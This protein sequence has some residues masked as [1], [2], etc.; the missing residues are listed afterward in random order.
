MCLS[1]LFR[2]FTCTTNRGSTV[3]G[4]LWQH[5]ERVLRYANRSHTM[6]ACGI[7]AGLSHLSLA[8]CCSCA[9]RR[10]LLCYHD[11][12]LHFR[13]LESCGLCS[14]LKYS[15]PMSSVPVSSTVFNEIA[16]IHSPTLSN[17]PSL[18]RNSTIFKSSFAPLPKKDRKDL[19]CA[20][21]LAQ[22]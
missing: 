20:P 17:T 10:I 12:E 7:S 4:W 1:A 3:I 19:G 13:S 9:S 11:V 15:I 2:V 8:R 14:H 22:D 21:Q 16:C 5:I 6:E 18:H